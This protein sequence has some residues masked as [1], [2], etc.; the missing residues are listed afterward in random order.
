MKILPRCS[1]LAARCSLLA[2]LLVSCA[3]PHPPHRQFS[4]QL[5]QGSKRIAV[6]GDQQRTSWIEFW[7]ESNTQHAEVVQRVA[8]Q[9]P[10]ALILLGDQVFWS[11]S[12]ADWRFFDDIMQPVHALNIPVFPLFGNHEYMGC[13][14]AGI[15][16][17][18]S[19]FA[20]ASTTWYRWDADSVAYIMLNSNWSSI[21]EDSTRMQLEWYTSELQRSE[22]DV[23]IRAIVVSSHH[24][25]YTN[26]TVVHDDVI[27]REEFVPLFLQTR[28]GQLWLSGH[29]HAIEMFQ[30][31]GKRFVVS[32]GGG[33]PR[34]KLN[35][36]E[37][38]QYADILHGGPVRPLHSLMLQRN[39]DSI[40]VSIDSLLSS[41]D[42]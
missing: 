27:S 33:G 6:I 29:C 18:Q 25:P 24:P 11:S 38:A 36:A 22:Q 21:G 35:T 5:R 40:L 20:A 13:G 34:Q 41:P 15:I 8:E 3:A 16:N 4:D 26:S 17:M 19:R 39:G 28:K 23:T 1:L 2:V 31:N 37:Y 10:D 42:R 7:K 30:R 9:R 32:G 12:A 14:D